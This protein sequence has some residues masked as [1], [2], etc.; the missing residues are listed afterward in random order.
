MYWIAAILLL[1]LAFM[2]WASA[3]VGSN[4][5]VKAT[6]RS[7]TDKKHIALTFDDGPDA[8]MTPR[9]LDILH[10]HNIRATFF[11]IGSKAERHP[12]IVRRM[13][14]EG[15]TVAIHTG[16]HRPTFPLSGYATVVAELEDCRKTLAGITG[17]A[18]RLFRPP[19]GVTNPV[20]GRAVRHLG[21]QT[22]GWSIRSLD[23]L[24]SGDVE[25]TARR[26]FRR[27]HPGAIVLLHDRCEN[28]DSLLEV[29]IKG[30]EDRGYR[31]VPIE[32][33]FFPSQNKKV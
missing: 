16:S 1:L 31:I 32:E 4:V 29:L 2:V 19:F 20:I 25:G 14:A 13:V 22:V 21:L 24:S 6:C 7:K 9:V 17:T 5:Y 28:A 12:C 11:L 15:H 33:G 8:D 30:I 26:V 18:P 10:K 23:T 3:D 27:L